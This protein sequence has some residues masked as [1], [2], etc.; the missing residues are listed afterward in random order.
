MDQAIN[1]AFHQANAGLPPE[2]GI[3]IPSGAEAPEII[4]IITRAA[5]AAR[6]KRRGDVNPTDI[7]IATEGDTVT[8]TAVSSAMMAPL[9]KAAAIAF[10]AAEG[11]ARAIEF[12]GTVRLRALEAQRAQDGTIAIVLG[13]EI[14]YAEGARERIE[15]VRH[16]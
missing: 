3:D 6:A 9:T 8:I 7:R 16:G 5:I 13:G 2:T 1:I 10:A 14:F 15:K 4:A 11:A 12:S